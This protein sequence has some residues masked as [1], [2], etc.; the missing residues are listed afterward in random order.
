M[1]SEVDGKPVTGSI[2]L[3]VAIRSHVPGEK[4][5]LTVKRAGKTRQVEVGLD[6]KT[7]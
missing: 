7:G 2:D 3:I 4:V 1:I 6:A 5:S